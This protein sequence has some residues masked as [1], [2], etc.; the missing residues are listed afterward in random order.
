MTSESQDTQIPETQE[1]EGT[2]RCLYTMA[3]YDE[4]RNAMIVDEYGVF[5][6]EQGRKVPPGKPVRRYVFP[7]SEETK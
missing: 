3:R 5:T 7:M 1:K 2:F 4:E 6:D